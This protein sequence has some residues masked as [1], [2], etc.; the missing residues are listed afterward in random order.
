MLVILTT[1]GDKDDA[2]GHDR[3]PRIS[4]RNQ[5]LNDPL[6]SNILLDFFLKTIRN[7]GKGAKNLLLFPR[8]S[9]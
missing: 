7:T 6:S 5:V 9:P 8:I 1:G 2:G 3:V 4:G